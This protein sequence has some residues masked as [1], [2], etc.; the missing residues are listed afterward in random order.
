[1]KPARAKLMSPCLKT[2]TREKGFGGLAPVVECLR[3][4]HET[5]VYC[6]KKEKIIIYGIPVHMKQDR[7]INILSGVY[8]NLCFLI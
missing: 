7:T 3:S 8:L 1:L 5:I 2:K 4:M 6:K